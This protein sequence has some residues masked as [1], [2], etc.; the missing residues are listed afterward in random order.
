MTTKTKTI[1]PRTTKVQEEFYEDTV[2]HEGGI[3]PDVAQNNA[4][5]TIVFENGCNLE[6]LRQTK[7]Y[8]CKSALSVVPVSLDAGPGE[9]QWSDAES[10]DFSLE[11][12]SFCLKRDQKI[13]ARTV[14]IGIDTSRG[15][16][17]GVAM[18]SYQTKVGD[19]FRIGGQWINNHAD[20]PF[21]VDLL[22]PRIDSRTLHFG[23]PGGEARL[24]HWLDLGVLHRYLIDRVMVCPAC[25]TLP[26]WRK[27]CNQCG[28]G[29]IDQDRLVHHFACAHVG[30]ANE[31]ETPAG[32]QCPK[33]RTQKLIV[34]SDFEY[35]NGPLKCFDCSSSGGLPAMSALCHRCFAR[36]DADDALEKLLYGYS[37]ERLNPGRDLKSSLVK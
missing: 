30:P 3:K 4:L 32:L 8:R 2:V 21:A 36:F 20:D 24:M 7:R 16:R 19:K 37:V 31:F 23:Y 35:I 17:F 18:L 22:R 27:G 26:T 34:G 5:E 28:S 15:R 10:V 12:I 11:G 13:E 29:R 9:V 1:A 14:V 6:E 25:E 33:C